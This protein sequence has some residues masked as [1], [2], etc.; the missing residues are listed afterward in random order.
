[1]KTINLVVE[2]VLSAA[3]L[4]KILSDCNLSAGTCYGLK[5]NSYIKKKIHAF[6]NASK[7]VPYIVLTDLDNTPCPPTLINEWFKNISIPKSFIFRV[8]VKEVESW[9]LADRC[10]FAK[11]IGISDT[12]IPHSVENIP[13]PKEF[14]INLAR[15][16]PK[17]DIREDIVPLTGSSAKRGRNYNGSLIKFVN[18]SWNYQAATK[19]SK[20]LN[21]AIN[22]I[23]RFALS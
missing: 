22:A 7:H 3:V 10:N 21:G 9:I 8:A 13:N 20:S 14:L 18:S 15:K 2:D 11:Y 17:R 5:G 1:M 12:A 19:Y 6:Y 4:R 23:K 16:S